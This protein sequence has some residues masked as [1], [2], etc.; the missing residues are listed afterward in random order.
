M[1]KIVTNT[2]E[3][4]TGGPVT[5]TKQE[6]VKHWV[7]YDSV[8]QTTD[9][10]LNQSTLTDNSEGYYT[11]TYVTNLSGGLGDKCIFTHTWNTVDDGAQGNSG[12]ARGGSMSS[13]AGEASLTT[14]ITWRSYYGSTAASDGAL[15]DMSGSYCMTLGDLA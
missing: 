15:E 5:L 12:Q 8:N 4:S 10:S 2:I 7:N 1:S 11:S 3:T 13:Q 9:G 6:A 14:N